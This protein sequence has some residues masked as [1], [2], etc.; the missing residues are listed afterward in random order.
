M[1]IS[2]QQ[3]GFLARRQVA[4]LGT[5]D[6]AG[7]PHVVPVCFACAGDTVFIAIDEKPKGVD[8]LMLKR[9]RNIMENPQVCLM[10]DRYSEEW[11][12]LGWVMLRGRARVQ[13][14]AAEVRT[15]VALLR[16][17]YRQYDDMALE[18]RPMIV[19]DIDL[20]T[21]WGDLTR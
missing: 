4:R 11:G 5:A 13:M 8:P 15:G 12:E 14:G 17:R 1:I 20:C 21:S 10:V 16:A 3:R 7:F 6:S 18:E 9:L 19:I 2:D